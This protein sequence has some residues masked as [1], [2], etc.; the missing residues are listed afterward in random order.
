MKRKIIS[1]LAAMAIVL[2]LAPC[3]LAD[4]FDQITD[5]ADPR[6]EDMLSAIEAQNFD[7]S[8]STAEHAK[9]VINHVLY[10]S[11]FA[12]FSG[13]QFGYP[14][15]GDY[16][17]VVSDGTYDVQIRGAKG[18][19]AL[20]SYVTNLTYGYDKGTWGLS[21][22]VGK[23]THT[24]ETFKALL[25]TQAQSGEHI[26]ID[27]KHSVAFISADE[28]GFYCID[29]QDFDGCTAML[30]YWKYSDFVNKYSDYEIGIYNSNSAVNSGLG[31]KADHKHDYV[32]GVCSICG[33]VLTSPFTDVDCES[34]YYEPVL[35]MYGRDITKGYTLTEY[36]TSGGCTRGQV[37]TFLWREEGSP[38]PKGGDCPFVDI[39]PRSYYYNAVMWASEQGIVKGYNETTFAPNETVT[40]AQFVTFLWRMKGKPEPHGRPNPFADVR[41][42]PYYKA[43]LWGS[44][45]GIVQGYENGYF[46]P[47][48]PCTRGHV[49]LFMYRYF[50]K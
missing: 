48:N 17:F 3:A 30:M 49:A 41:M 9:Q 16:T 42:S 40:R 36:D 29:Y 50:V 8:G 19:Y 7:G 45:R 12:V 34:V 33:Y 43:I 21:N 32:D 46:R 23:Q 31:T 28:D 2:S 4:G 38:L 5:S 13:G 11:D 14:N 6:I 18:C 47:N 10:K 20:S 26:R 39:D 35:W 15:S 24:A 22:E 37:V 25:V 44:E 1:L 27:D